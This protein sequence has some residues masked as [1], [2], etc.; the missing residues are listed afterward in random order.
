[1]SHAPTRGER[2]I[3]F[4]EGFLRVPEGKKVGQ[5][6]VLDKFQRRFVLDVYDNPSGTRKAILSVARKAGKTVLI[7][8]L[9]LAHVAGPE[10]IENS[11]IV[12][13]AM[14]RDQAALVFSAASKMVAL[15]PELRDRV[16]VIPSG[17]RLIGLSKGVEYRALAADGATAHGLSPVL[18]ILDEVGQIKGATDDFVDAIVTSQ[19]A[20][21]EPL[22]ILISTQAPSDAAYLSLEIDDALTGSDP[23]TVVHLYAS[24]KDC[25]LMDAAQWAKA[26]P[27]SFRS[28]EDIKRLA[29]A[30][31]RVP[32]KEP[33]FR[34]LILNQR[35]ELFAPFVGR[36]AWK[37][38][39]GEVEDLAGQTVFAGL[40][41][42]AV[43]DL[44]SLVLVWRRGQEWC[45]R[46]FFWT[47]A[48]GL[49]DR[50]QR[51]RQPYETWVKQGDLLTTPG[52]TIDYEFIAQFMARLPVK[53]SAIGFDRWRID[54]FKAAMGR[55]DV[56][57]SVR[58][59]MQPFGQGMASM[60]PALDTLERSIVEKRFRHGGHPVLT[61][62]AA[63]A[64][65]ET[66]A[67][68]NRKL[69][70]QKSNGRIDGMIALA[71]AM[72]VASVEAAETKQY[73]M[74]VL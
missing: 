37:T 33:A 21:D 30:A 65:V 16:R 70:K 61:M 53:Y 67:A 48:I 29:E 5:P 72:G 63:N 40:D 36:T 66:D 43:Q 50:A 62:C 42:S 68:G 10:A 13:G 55:V 57:D 58:D 2:V 20:Y 54:Q 47:P 14:S 71:M 4:I 18:A 28:V 22:L 24:D 1:M 32:A 39:D 34:N 19:G 26:N 17:K 74:L 56:P 6:M 49:R 9:V 45:C 7:A 25:D 60:A 12:S 51:D 35:V 3:A 15:S 31:L 73:Q 8:S 69:T 59:V 52:S 23:H 44:T 46:P 64:T 41:L 27:S 11:Q 38:C